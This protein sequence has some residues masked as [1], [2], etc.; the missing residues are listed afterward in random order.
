MTFNHIYFFYQ[1]PIFVPE[2]LQNF[3]GFAF[4]LA[5]NNFNLVIFFNLNRFRYLYLV[6][7]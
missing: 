4:V 1:H 3:P 7:L 2:H 5:G 6:F